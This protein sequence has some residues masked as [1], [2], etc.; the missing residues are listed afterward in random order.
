LNVVGGKNE[1]ISGR[2]GTTGAN[3]YLFCITVCRASLSDWP[4]FRLFL[5]IWF[6]WDCVCSF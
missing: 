3:F 2:D 1:I 4:R 6:L 5:I